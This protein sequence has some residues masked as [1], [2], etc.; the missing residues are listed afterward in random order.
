MK[1]ML[2]LMLTAALLMSPL[3]VNATSVVK[4][5]EVG[6]T[7]EA[8]EFSLKLPTVI[9]FEKVTIGSG[10]D[11]HTTG[12]DG[13]IIIKDFRGNHAGYRLDV[14]ASQFKNEKNQTIPK[15]SLKLAPAST[16]IKLGNGTS[17]APTIS[18][19]TEQIVDGSNVEVAK[20]PAGTGMGGFKVS[21]PIKA[22]TL[23]TDSTSINS[24]SYK[25]VFTWSLVQAP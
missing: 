3:A 14:T 21:F 7:V 24:G 23:T 9:N 2:A 16:I 1:K 8:G 6:V 13:D 10:V 5:S 12:F 17:K 22:L 19:T 15:G 4:T 25:S 11:V 20:A 18:Q